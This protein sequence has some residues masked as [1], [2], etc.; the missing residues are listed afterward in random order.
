MQYFL[1]AVLSPGH[2]LQVEIYHGDR[3]LLITHH[4]NAS[5]VVKQSRLDIELWLN[6]VLGAEI[7]SRGLDYRSLIDYDLQ[8]YE[9]RIHTP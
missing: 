5:V 1:H 4:N 3:P 6:S 2:V 7:K 9:V 8:L